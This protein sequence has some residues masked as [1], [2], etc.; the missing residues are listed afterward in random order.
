MST[1]VRFQYNDD[2][3]QRILKAVKAGLTPQKQNAVLQRAA[4]V[5]HGRLV[6]QTP[7]KWTGQTRRAWTVV[8]MGPSGYAVTNK[9][10][11]MRFLELGTRA[12]GPKTAMRLFIPLNRSAA[13]AGPRVCCAPG[14]K[15][16]FGRDYLLVKRV[17]GIRAL[18]IVERYRPFA[19]G[20]IKAAMKLHVREIIQS[21]T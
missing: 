10:K 2:R 13:L 11:V 5:I 9:S 20:C 17:R 8:N 1:P 6:M 7:K 19:E 16:R 15:Y 12:H 14:S 18:K 21:V 4:W 3:G